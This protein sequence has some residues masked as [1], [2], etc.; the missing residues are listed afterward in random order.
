MLILFI[1][2]QVQ[3]LIAGSPNCLLE[4]AAFL[5]KSPLKDSPAK[6]LPA[7]FVVKPLPVIAN[8]KDDSEKPNHKMEYSAENAVGK[9]SLS[10][11]KNGN[12][13]TNGPYLGSPQ[14]VAT[15]TDNK[16]V[17]LYFHQAAGPQWLVP[18]MSPS[19]GLIYKPYSGPGMMG[20]VFGGH[21]PFGS[22]PVTGNFANSAYGIPVSHQGISVFPGTHPVGHPYFPPYGMPVSNPAMSGSAVEQVSQ[23]SGPGSHS[24]TG[25]TQVRDVHPNVEQQSSCN[26]P[27]K[28]NGSISQARKFQASKGSDLQRS[29]ASSPNERANGNGTSHNAEGRDPLPLFPLVPVV[30]EVDSQPHDTD[31]ATRV[32]KV[33]PHNARSATE[34]AARIF[35]FIQQERKQF[36]SV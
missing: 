12:H 6:K 15:T 29:T 14:P 20:A 30:P 4:D 10:S 7:E 26:L 18:V 23:F 24:Q 31:Q 3:R 11:V 21:G 17:P 35:H 36:D 34:S 33:V 16:M 2:H 19:E 22:T 8:C 5:G 13:S 28:K 25:Q 9:T 32:I 27:T 1:F